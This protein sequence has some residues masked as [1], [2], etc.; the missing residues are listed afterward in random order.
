MA[1]QLPAAALEGLELVELFLEAIWVAP[2]EFLV[3]PRLGFG[4]ACGG[5]LGECAG[6]LGG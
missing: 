2:R 4:F 3:A 1:S 5:G 6:G